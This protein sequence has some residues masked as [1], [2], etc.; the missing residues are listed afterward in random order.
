MKFAG[1][2]IKL[3]IF[4]TKRGRV[5]TCHVWDSLRGVAFLDR[6]GAGAIRQSLYRPS[7][8]NFITIGKP[9]TMKVH[10]KIKAIN[11]NPTGDELAVLYAKTLPK[12]F[13]SNFPS[14]KK[15]Y[16]DLSAIIHSGKESDGAKKCLAAIRVA[17][18]GHFKAIQ[19][20][21]EIPTQ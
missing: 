6:F 2:S 8:R 12:N 4:G 18:D 7:D 5:H 16:D 15:A 9:S 14:L 10:G 21:K 19:L 3:L 11:G 17:V 20:F 1:E 13:P